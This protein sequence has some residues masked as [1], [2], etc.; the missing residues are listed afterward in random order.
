MMAP[1]RLPRAP[2]S[3]WLRTAF[4]MVLAMALA[5][6]LE[7]RLPGFFFHDDNQSEY[8][9]ASFEVARL[10]LHGQLPILSDHSWFG[11]ALAGEYQYGVFSIYALGCDLFVYAL[12]LT[13]AHSAAMLAALHLA[14]AAGGGFRLARGRGL[15]GALA[16]GTAC[17]ACSAGWL[18]AWG[19]VWVPALAS[20]AWLPWLWW[21][22]ERQDLTTAGARPVR[23]LLPALFV[24]LIL[25]AGWPFTVAMAVLVT[26]C[27]CLRAITR[28]G[29]R[30]GRLRARWPFPAAWALGGLLAAPA[31]L[32]LIQYYHATK[33]G[34]A[35]SEWSSECTVPWRALASL[36]VPPFQVKW[37]LFAP[38]QLGGVELACGLVPVAILVA[39]LLRC[40][41]A[42]LRAAG[43]ELGLVVVSFAFACAPSYGSMRW[44]FRWLPL[45][46]LALALASMEALRALTPLGRWRR[47]ECAACGLILFAVTWALG[48]AHVDARA[49]TP[50]V[51]A[52]AAWCAL[53]WLAARAAVPAAAAAYGLPAVVIVAQ[54][55]AFTHMIVFAYPPT[56]QLSESVRHATPLDPHRTYLGIRGASDTMGPGANGRWEGRKPH[57]L[58]G[59]LSMLSGLTFV[60]GYSPMGPAGLSELFRFHS[61]GDLIGNPITNFAAPWWQQG[62]LIAEIGVDGLLVSERMLDLP[63][64]ARL[65][66]TGWREVTTVPGGVVYHAQDPVPRVRALARA[67]AFPTLAA[68]RGHRA[69]PIWE[70]LIIAP[71]GDGKSE[72]FSTPTLT[73]R[74]E[75]P[76]RVE[77][78]IAVPAQVDAMVAFTRAWYPGYEA[79][80]DDR[81]LRVDQLDLAVPVVRVP[82]GAHGHLVLEYSPDALTVGFVL[83]GLAV[84]TALL[85]ALASVRRRAHSTVAPMQVASSMTDSV[86]SV[87]TS[88][89]VAG[90][91]S[92]ALPDAKNPS[93]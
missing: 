50:L 87:R 10:L 2:S 16:L 33:R 8:L 37:Y 62:G 58:P 3:E 60:N 79:Y 7:W 54:A 46:H 5:W 32:M 15:S 81:A 44:P 23:C 6:L 35:A 39:A 36:V 86:A 66:A 40:P 28:H 63:T 82:A 18:M 4:V 90:Q 67:M 85:L 61:H 24:Y 20:F 14:V 51:I 26:A 52:A 80:L 88:R 17:I 13:L 49:A 41:R 22:L 55:L 89:Q 59:N 30:R 73:L 47:V 75:A 93:P 71:D 27:A 45:F 25:T 68:L 19:T 83:A 69:G 56:W 64:R 65:S 70:A 78:D 92:I 72:R 76:R 91:S 21:S 11:G 57:L 12:H 42:L 34:G 53:E 1:L 9:P 38:G 84:C 77:V 31:L 43:W 48:A 29:S 74:A